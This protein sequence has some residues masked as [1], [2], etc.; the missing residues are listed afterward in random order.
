[1][2]ENGV[3]NFPDPQFQDGGGVSLDVPDGA[4]PQRVNAAQQKCKSLMPNGGENQKVDPKVTEQLRKYSK[5][6]RDNGVT[7]FPD[8]GPEGGLQINNDQLGI[9]VDDPKY[10]AAERTCSQHMPKP[11][12]G[13]EGTQTHGAGGGA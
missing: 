7:Q 5:C 11:P 9:S 2:R 4:D 1:M 13:G 6:M 12:G 10:I 8:P 3:A